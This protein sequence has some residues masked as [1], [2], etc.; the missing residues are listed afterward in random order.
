MP[1]RTNV[2]GRAL[3]NTCVAWRNC[4]PNDRCRAAATGNDD[5]RGAFKTPTLREVARTS[6]YMHD[7]SFATLDDVVEYYDRGAQKNPGLDGRVRPLGLSAADRQNLVE[8]LKTL[9]GRIQDG[10]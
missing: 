6:P 7:G 3:H 10:R 4:A 5:D 1:Q 2:Y 9:S 8:F